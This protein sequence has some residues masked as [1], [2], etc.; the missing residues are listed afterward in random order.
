MQRFNEYKWSILALALLL[1]GILLSRGGLASLTP[2]LRLIVPVVIVIFA[3]NYLKKRLTSGA[4]GEALRKRME[5]AMRQQQM[6][7]QGGRDKVIDL[8][9]KCGTYLTAGHRCK[10]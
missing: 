1:G 6:N 5:E 10:K 2:L 4:V 8:C 9:P 3:F 7:A